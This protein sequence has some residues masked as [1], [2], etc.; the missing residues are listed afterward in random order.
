MARTSTKRRCS[1]PVRARAL[2]HVPESAGNATAEAASDEMVATG[3]GTACA[4]GSRPRAQPLGGCGPSSG[5][6][7]T[8]RSCFGPS[9]ACRCDGGK[10]ASAPRAHLQPG[11]WSYMASGPGSTTR[12]SSISWETRQCRMCTRS[13]EPS[14]MRCATLGGLRNLIGRIPSCLPT[15][16]WR[17]VEWNKYETIESALY[18][19][20]QRKPYGST[21]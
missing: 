21:Q 4:G 17:T 9:P 13:S 2:R 6:S 14:Q 19:T 16:R 12:S 7:Y 8:A 10:C 5:R 11:F 3:A 1:A 18:K 15:M 20:V